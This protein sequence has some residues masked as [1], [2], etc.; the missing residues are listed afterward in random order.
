MGGREGGGREGR[1]GVVVDEVGFDAT[2]GK[3]REGSIR[4]KE[5]GREGGRLL[6]EGGR[7]GGA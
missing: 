4:S 3:R 7:E 5:G 2:N 6:H 1:A